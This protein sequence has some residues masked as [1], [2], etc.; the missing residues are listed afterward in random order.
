MKT[1]TLNSCDTTCTDMNPTFRR[2][3]IRG[4]S[5]EQKFL[6]A[7]YFYDER[8]DKLFQQ[9]MQCPEYYLTDA[10]MDIM[11]H[12]SDRILDECLKMHA[13]FDIVELGAG[14]ASKTI[15]LLK[16]ALERGI[17]DH[18]YPIDISPNT[19]GYLEDNLP[20]QLPGMTIEGLAGEYFQMLEKLNSRQ[21][22][23]K[24]VLFLGATIGNMAPE[25]AKYFCKELQTYMNDGDILLIGFD[26]KKDPATI[27]AA[28]N[29]AA[30][31]TAAFNYNLLDRINRELGG[32]FNTEM[33]AH[34]PV[35]DP[36]TGSCK[37]YLISK[38]HQA[39]TLDDG[40]TFRFDKDEAIF[41]E[42]SQKYSLKDINMLAK[43]SG[44]TPLTSFF[45]SRSLFVD[46]LWKVP[47]LKQFLSNTPG[48]ISDVRY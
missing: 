10:E 24:L 31:I 45:D 17:A 13:H 19:I 30:G 25:E 1:T 12:Q 40:T 2:D 27:L 41:M 8:G 42:V 21:A 44:F 11:L 22:K 16:R 15:H 7:K 36:G 20:Q 6:E 3:V 29:D 9:I 37:S 33:F 5:A 43:A 28:Y 39:V 34:Y 14:D 18:Y 26:L 35:Y 32:N 4:L 38:E 23:P 47:G 46:A 48:K